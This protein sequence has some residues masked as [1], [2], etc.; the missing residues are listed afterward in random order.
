M[1]AL[2]SGLPIVPATKT[3]LRELFVQENLKLVS[4]LADNMLSNIE[5]LLLR[6]MRQ[7]SHVRE[8]EKQLQAEIGLSKRRAQLIARDQVNKYSGDLTRHNQ[9]EAGITH[10]RWETS[11]DE[12]VR[13][14]HRGLNGKVFTWDKPPIS[15]KSGG[16]YHP[17]QGINCR[18]DAIPVISY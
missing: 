2:L 18:C 13:S 11:G 14:R 7:G 5:T 16:H 3:Q 8:I 6:S 12:R 1:M 9:K 4:S 15:D 17:R 10:Y